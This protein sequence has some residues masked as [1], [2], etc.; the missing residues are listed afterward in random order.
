MGGCE[1]NDGLFTFINHIDAYNHSIG[2]RNLQSVEVESYFSID[3][4]EEVSKDTYLFLRESGSFYSISQHKLRRDAN[5][6]KELLNAFLHFLSV[7]D[8]HSNLDHFRV[9]KS[10][11]AFNIFLL[12]GI[13]LKFAPLRLLNDCS[14]PA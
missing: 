4:F 13:S 1:S 5:S 7:D 12:S 6:I 10:L 2:K 9:S 14:I 8:N 3:L 11:Q